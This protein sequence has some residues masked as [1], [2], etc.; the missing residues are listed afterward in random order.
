MFLSKKE[1]KQLKKWKFE[2]ECFEFELRGDNLFSRI[3][4]NFC[5]F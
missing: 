3:I 5:S 1:E 2:I 4:Y